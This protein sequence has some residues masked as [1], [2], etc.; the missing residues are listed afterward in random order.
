MYFDV[1]P[2]NERREREALTAKVRP[3]SRLLTFQP[4]VT[5]IHKLADVEEP[6][7]PSAELIK[8]I[9]DLSIKFGDWWA[10]V[11]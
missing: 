5:Q 1:M 4:T 2:A 6:A 10:D 9:L 11:N 3:L 7:V 8:E